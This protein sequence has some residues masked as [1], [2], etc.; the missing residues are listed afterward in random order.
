MLAQRLR[1]RCR[2]EQFTDE[3]NPSTGEMTRTWSTF[4]TDVPIEIVPSSG[5]EYVA[6]GGIQAGVEA[7]ATVREMDGLVSAMRVIRTVNGVDTAVYEIKAVLPDP[8]FKRHLTLMLGSGVS[9][10]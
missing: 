10:G 3:Q 9:N 4:A 1:H 6:G 5:R 8:T 2:I 7:R